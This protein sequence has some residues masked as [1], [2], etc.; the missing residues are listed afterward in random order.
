M[1]YKK[2]SYNEKDWEKK[3]QRVHEILRSKFERCEIQ[4]LNVGI[5]YRGI[6]TLEIGKMELETV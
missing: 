6:I 3:G 4:E 1:E 5:D 2:L